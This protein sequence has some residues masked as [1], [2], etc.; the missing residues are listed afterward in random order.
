MTGKAMLVLEQK[1]VDKI[2]ENRGDLN[3]ADFIEFCI[4]N[5]LRETEHEEV[6][7]RGPDIAEETFATKPKGTAIYATRE[8][9]QE[10]KRGIT[11]LLRTFLDF[12]ITF[13]LELGTSKSTET[14][15]HLKSQLRD[16]L[17]ER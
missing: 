10:F 15:G 1:L 14:V 8:E 17:G 11:N 7:R 3:R 13:G 9:F 6:E 2:D 5:C 4:D 12:F 16:I